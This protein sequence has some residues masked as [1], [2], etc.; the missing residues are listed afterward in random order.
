MVMNE[1]SFDIELLCPFKFQIDVNYGTYALL[2]TH[3]FSLASGSFQKSTQYPVLFQFIKFKILVMMYLWFEL[4]MFV[5]AKKLFNFYFLIDQRISKSKTK[6]GFFSNQT[7]ISR[8]ECV[9][10]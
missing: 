10:S 3:V 7:F 2:F 9:K 4:L 1:I 5:Y 8:D 6:D